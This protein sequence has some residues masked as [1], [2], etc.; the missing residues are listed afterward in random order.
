MIH[1]TLPSNIRTSGL[2]IRVGVLHGALNLEKG[3]EFLILMKRVYNFKINSQKCKRM[4]IG[5]IILHGVLSNGTQRPTVIACP[6]H[7]YLRPIN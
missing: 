5:I 2:C 4:I 1:P 3:F 6:L 7:L